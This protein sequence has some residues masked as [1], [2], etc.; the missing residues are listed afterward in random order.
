MVN[1]GAVQKFIDGRAIGIAVSYAGVSRHQDRHRVEFWFAVESCAWCARLTGI[2]L[3]AQRVRLTHVR[4][5][6]AR[7]AGS[8]AHFGCAIEL[9]ASADAEVLF[10]RKAGQL[11]V[12]NADPYLNRLLV[13]LCEESARDAARPAAG[14]FERRSRMRLPR[15]FR[16]AKPCR[17]T[18]ARRS[19]GLE[20]ANPGAVPHAGPGTHRSRTC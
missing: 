12:V 17:S 3:L 6:A 7:A 10:A 13:G 9:G 16:T 1:E 14:R 2:R 15:C 20:P 18:V 4:A 5:R 11:P 19:L 8:L